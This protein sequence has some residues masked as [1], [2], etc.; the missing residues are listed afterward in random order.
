MIEGDPKGIIVNFHIAYTKEVLVSI[1]GL[2]SKRDAGKL[3][4]KKAIWVDEH[5]NKYVGLV[6]GLHG[7]S[8]TVKVKFKNPLPA[9]SLGKEI[10]IAG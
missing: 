2:K 1:P 9:K 6:T 3:V 10:G 7:R 5:G 4:G 8:G